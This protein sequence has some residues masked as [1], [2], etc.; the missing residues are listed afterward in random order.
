MHP[1]MLFQP[2]PNPNNR[3]V[4]LLQIVENSDPE[5][6]KWNATNLGRDQDALRIL[7]KIK[8]INKMR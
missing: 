6:K 3:P 2:N 8:T 5:I 7:R 1:Q 4:Q